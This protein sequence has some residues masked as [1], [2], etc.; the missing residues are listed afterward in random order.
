MIPNP[1]I[2]LRQQF[3]KFLDRR[4]NNHAVAEDILQTA[5]LRALEGAGSLRTDESA[6][7]WFYRILRNSIIDHYRRRTS[8]SAALDR[9]ARE[10]EDAHVPEPAL[11]DTACRCIVG[12]L[13]SLTPAYASLLR[14]V[15]LTEGSLAE[16]AAAEGITPGNAAVR[17]HRARAAL[18]K[19]LIA[20]CGTCADHGCI[21]CTC[22]HS[23]R[24]ALRKA[25][26]QE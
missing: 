26:R 12:A 11:M 19:Q 2:D 1:L 7:A 3:V 22:D 17:A 20:C 24:V 14:A 21:D 15:D 5:Y 23:T 18:R 10:L 13:D 25:A 6:V 9:W 16:Y 4:V 8:E